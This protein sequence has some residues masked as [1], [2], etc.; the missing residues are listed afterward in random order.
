MICAMGAISLLGF[1]VWAFLLM[2]LQLCEGLVIKSCYMLGRL[3]AVDYALGDP[4]G[5]PQA[6]ACGPKSA[7][8]NVR[9]L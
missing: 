4:E 1:I 8:H 9:F 7:S 5:T 3:Y 2:G 6:Y